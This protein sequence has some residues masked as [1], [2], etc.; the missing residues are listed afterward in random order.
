M[1]ALLVFHVVVA[2]KDF[3]LNIPTVIVLSSFLT[4]D[5][6][7]RDTGYCVFDSFTTDIQALLLALPQGNF[8][9]SRREE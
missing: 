9:E 4:L 3:S 5:L 2:A 8:Q 6:N 7:S 1:A